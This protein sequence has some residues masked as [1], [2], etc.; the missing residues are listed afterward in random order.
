MEHVLDLKHLTLAVNLV[1]EAIFVEL[2]AH[3]L[4]KV[5]KHTLMVLFLDCIADGT[6]TVAFF[7]LL[8]PVVHD[9]GQV[10]VVG[11]HSFATIKLSLLFSL[12]TEG[13][14]SVQC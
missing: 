5:D 14:P 12:S 9:G 8:K 10:D 3:T 7:G 6:D 4:Q 11:E 2:D 1:D 13:Q